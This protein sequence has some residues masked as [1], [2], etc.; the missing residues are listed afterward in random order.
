MHACVGAQL[1]RQRTFSRDTQ[2]SVLPKPK[3][4][5]LRFSLLRCGPSCER[6]PPTM[7]AAEDAELSGYVDL[8]AGRRCS[9]G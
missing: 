3:L 4:G 8:R 2:R 6:V 5:A 1:H 9:H 7:I